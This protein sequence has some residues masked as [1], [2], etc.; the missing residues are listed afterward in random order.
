MKREDFVKKIEKIYA[1]G[2]EIIRQKNIDY[3]T[4]EDPLKN[5][6]DAQI[7]G[8]DLP[9][10]ILVRVADKLSRIGNMLKP[11]HVS[12][13]EEKIED[14]LL[15]AINLMAFVLYCLQQHDSK[16]KTISLDE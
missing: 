10:A 3:A 4:V 9:H 5:F 13:S 11:G 16:E 8:V 6:A 15:D 14:T 7:V 2:I 12:A 1:D